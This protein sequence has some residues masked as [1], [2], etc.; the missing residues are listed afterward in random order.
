M[1]CTKTQIGYKDYTL[2][3][4][5][6]SVFLNDLIVSCAF[7]S[8]N[9]STDK[10][11]HRNGVV[12]VHNIPSLSL[13]I[14]YFYAKCIVKSSPSLSTS[15]ILQS[16]VH[17]NIHSIHTWY[18]IV[19]FSLSKQTHVLLSY[20]TL[21]DWLVLSGAFW[22]SA[23]VDTVLF[24]CSTDTKKLKSTQKADSGEENSPTTLAGTWTWHLSI[25]SLWLCHILNYPHS[26]TA[27]IYIIIKIIVS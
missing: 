1:C 14:F 15:Q 2:P 25:M 22:I 20:V 23:K 9:S 19:Q 17:T 13:V 27:S 3:A 11:R 26:K 18:I 24:S 4:S 8:S 6:V 5:L 10:Y 12:N 16:S 21:N 7:R